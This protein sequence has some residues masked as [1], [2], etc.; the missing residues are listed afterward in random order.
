M[1][2]EALKHY[3]KKGIVPFHMPGHKRNTK[4]LGSGLPY[5]I[6]ITEIY[7]FDN[8]QDPKGILKTVAERAAVLYR[9]SRAFPLVNGATGGIL[10]A[11]KSAVCSGDT[12]IMARNCHKSV[13]SAV[14][15]FGLRP[16]YI[17]PEAE[18]SGICGSIRPGQINKAIAEHPDASLIILTSPTYEGVVSDVRSIAD[19]AHKRSIP[20][21]IDAAHGAHLGFSDY[22][23]PSSVSCGAD[24]AVKSLHKT[25]PALTQCALVL[26][27]GKIVDP[28]RLR[29]A[30]TLFQTSSP[31][32]VLLS[33]IDRCTE[34]L[35]GG[36]ER[37]FNAYIEKLN[38]FDA[39]IKDL[40]RLCVI[41]HGAD[42]MADHKSFFSFDPG[43]IVI[44]S[45]EAGLSGTELS[46]LLRSGYLLELE[47]AGPGHAVAMTSICD[48]PEHF[49]RLADALKAVDSKEK[50]E[51]AIRP[52]PLP[53]LPELH[54]TASEAAKRKGV[55]TPLE[56]ACGSVALEYV[57]AYP[58]GIPLLVP[59]EAVN[60]EL[61][62][63]IVR[64]IEMGIEVKST[65]G[66]LPDVYTLP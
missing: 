24:I 52:A 19:I 53:P 58:P 2:Y 3:S 62:G 6:D 63:H 12:V 54:M 1:L 13:Y 50:K 60:G 25:L 56:R 16:V 32:Y 57:W 38:D 37:L 65:K 46:A 59:G 8:L 41:C 34:L 18:K 64:L 21:L 42:G 44:L 9:C 27:N 30:V 51:S 40:K 28:D 48:E 15:L 61:A 66:R 22:F 26:Q 23:P 20:V 45:R 29:E 55:F 31:S 47:M 7:G 33:S 5:D 43:K 14:E 11:V 36:K 35:E 10:A 17:M 49:I 39:R 4:L